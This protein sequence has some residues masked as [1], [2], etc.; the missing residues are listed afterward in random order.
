MVLYPL[1]TASHYDA[2]EPDLYHLTTTDGSIIS[3]SRSFILNAEIGLAPT[4]AKDYSYKLRRFT[5][6]CLDA[7]ID[8][9]ADVTTNTARAFIASMQR[10]GQSPNS[11]S[12]F[13]KVARRFFSWMVEEERLDRNPLARVKPRKPPEVIIKP[14]SPE[15]IRKILLLCD[16][17]GSIF[18]SRRNRAMVLI[19][20]DTGLR[21]SELA[22]MR[23]HQIDV[24]AGT[25]TVMGKG[26][27]ERVV[28]VSKTTLRA[29]IRYY[30]LCPTNHPQLWLTEKGEPMALNSV[31]QV[32]KMLKRRAGFIDVRLSA[33]TFRHT[34]GTDMLLNGA[35]EREV[36][37]LL[38]HTTSR[39]TRHYTA[40]I[41][42]QQ[43][44]SRHKD[45][46]P[47][48]RMGLK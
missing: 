29:I 11:I 25:I 5:N 30:E 8:Q 48:E 27:R 4:T 37:L 24:R 28:G 7:G 16:N 23:T 19:L 36:Q 40:T 26:S 31:S 46:S 32:F 43:I 20:L 39:M 47:V 21:I 35:S 10:A 3:Q 44:V 15:H 12:D 17:C 45:F 33:H 34:S 14:F 18:A 6:F 13:Y 2:P 42:S 9:V 1:T 38:G 22:A 41:T